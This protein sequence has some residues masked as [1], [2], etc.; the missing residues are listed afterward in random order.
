MRMNGIELYE[1][2]LGE[3]V[4]CSDLNMIVANYTTKEKKQ[5]LGHFIL[6]HKDKIYQ[7][8]VDAYSHE[9][10]TL[11]LKLVSK[12]L[13]KSQIITHNFFKSLT[14]KS[15][16]LP[17]Q[18]FLLTL[19]FM[20]NRKITGCEYIKFAY[21]NKRIEFKHGCTFIEMNSIKFYNSTNVVV[22]Y[23]TSI[24]NMKITNTSIFIEA[25]DN[26]QVFILLS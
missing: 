7:L 17:I 16:E 12:T 14:K 25:K 24:L 20:F 8:L 18:K 4:E 9:K 11:I 26:K 23:N 21:P 3:T 22:L 2:L 1:K 6:Q 5:K 19:N 13:S 10:Q 15:T